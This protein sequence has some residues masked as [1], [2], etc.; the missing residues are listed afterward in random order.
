[1]LDENI[2]VGDKIKFT[3]LSNHL[4]TKNK[5][6]EVI[7]KEGPSMYWI[8]CDDSSERWVGIS[9]SFSDWEKVENTKKDIDFL[10]M[11]KGY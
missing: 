9:Q 3:G 2:K 11:L 1:M 6:Y 7:R 5:I 4:V 10:D 8:I